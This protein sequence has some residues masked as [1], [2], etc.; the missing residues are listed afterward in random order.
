MG[1]QLLST[2][3]PHLSGVG[4]S[5][6]RVMDG[7][8]ARMPE[9]TTLVSADNHWGLAEDPWKG[10]VPVHLANRVPTVWWDAEIGLWNWRVGDGPAVFNAERA[11][12]LK[13]VEDR[14]GTAIIEDRLA[15]M[16]AD[17]VAMEIAF[18]QLL[19]MFNRHPDYEAR[20]WIFRIYNEYMAEVAAR[21]PG[22][23]HGVG[24]SNFW[25]MS[26]AETSLRHLKDLG[27]KTFMLPLTPGNDAEGRTIHYASDEMD[28]LWATAEELDLPVFF[29]AGEN[30]PMGNPGGSVAAMLGIFM[31]FRKQ[32]SDLVF[33]GILD[34]HPNLKIVF[35]ESGINW[36]PGMLQDAEMIVDSCE[37]IM[38]PKLEMRP[39]DY[40]RRNCYATV[41]S[42]A[43][44]FKLLDYIGADRVMFAVDY[45]H[46]EG[47][48]GYT[49][50]AI[51][52]IVDAVSSAD[53]RKILGGTAIEVF[54]LA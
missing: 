25:D 50:G 45:P 26:K 23:F 37:A 31:P 5:R 16:D 20:E 48:Q 32:F 39:T 15:D 28:V 33:G 43:I 7:A 46:N 17:G 9:G 41:M 44:G 40:W 14:R 19:P 42:D 13:T 30:L 51:E 18:P 8:Q 12:G 38:D 22:R 21:A 3:N 4:L 47:V 29:H 6:D 27:L 52:N 53:A 36:I 49:R 11:A 24:F 1:S 35:A 10:R 54:N 2:R 34:R